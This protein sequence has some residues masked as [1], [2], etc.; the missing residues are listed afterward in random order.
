MRRSVCTIFAKPSSVWVEKL[1]KTRLGVEGVVGIKSRKIQSNANFWN[2]IYIKPWF[3]VDLRVPDCVKSHNL[4]LLQVLFLFLL[5][6]ALEPKDWHQAS[7][8]FVCTGSVAL[9]LYLTL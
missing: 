4:Q 2:A 7:G 6:Y 8:I 9:L 5:W 1:Q 3:F